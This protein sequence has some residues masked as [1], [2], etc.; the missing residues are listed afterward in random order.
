MAVREQI[1]PMRTLRWK[2]DVTIEFIS[3][4]LGSQPSTNIGLAHLRTKQ[5]RQLARELK[6][7]LR[8]E[9]QA[10]EVARAEIMETLESL[11]EQKEQEENVTVFPRD[12]EGRIVLLSHQIEGY[13]KERAQLLRPQRP[14]RR[15]SGQAL[16]T[17]QDVVSYLFVLPDVIPLL[18]P[19]GSVVTEEDIKIYQRPLRRDGGAPGK[20]A[21]AIAYSEIVEPP[22]VASFTVEAHG[23]LSGEPVWEPEHLEALLEYGERYGLG[24][25]RNGGYGRFILTSFT[26]TPVKSTKK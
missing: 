11:A 23:P 3:P 16:L 18:R 8:S 6:K 12:R 10:N 25:F 14:S 13:L 15:G 17:R 4:V 26:V 22:V 5:I 20:Q 21:V 9:E 19:D 7:V 24:Q 1:V 2:A